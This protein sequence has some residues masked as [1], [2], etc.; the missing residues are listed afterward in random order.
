MAR[1]YKPTTNSPISYQI[2]RNNLVKSDICRLLNISMFTLN[3]YIAE[4]G[5]IRFKDMYKLAAV[6]NLGILEFIYCLERNKPQLKKDDKWYI[7]EIIQRA[8]K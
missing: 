3:S 6:F 7:E 5:Q 2:K 1:N 4:P 8:E